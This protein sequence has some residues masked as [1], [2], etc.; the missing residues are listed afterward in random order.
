MSGKKSRFRPDVQT[1]AQSVPA[2]QVP[3]AEPITKQDQIWIAAY[4]V[5][6]F[7]AM[8]VQTG[9]MA[10]V[11]TALA[12][13]LSI[14]KGPLKRFRGRFCI[15]VI[16]LL[17]MAM[18]NGLADLNSGASVGV[19]RCRGGHLPAVYRSEQFSEAV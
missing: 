2:S 19:R 1:A 10:L 3:A 15:P 4:S 9:T 14:G 5:L 6:L 16:G 7:L 8:T 17:D 18:R 13:V 12:L 11:L